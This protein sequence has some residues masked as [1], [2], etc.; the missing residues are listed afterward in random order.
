MSE[1]RSLQLTLVLAATIFIGQLHLF[2]QT[3]QTV[4]DFQLAPGQSSDGEGITADAIGNVF[5]GGN[6]YDAAGT[7]HGLVLKTDTTQATWYLS[8]DTNPNATQYQ[9]SMWNLGLDAG[10]NAYSIG[11][12]TPLSTGIPFWYVRKSSDSGQSW[13]TVDLYQYTAGKWIDATGFA[14]DAAGNIF[15]VG[16]GKDASGYNHWLVRK[17]TD[18]GQTWA[19]VDDVKGY[20][21]FH[22]G[23]VPGVGVFVVGGPYIIP[24]SW[25][26]RRSLDAGANWQTV[27]GPFAQGAARGVA[28]DSQGNIYVSGSMF[29][30]TQVLKVKGQITTN[31]YYAWITRRSG[32][33]GRT[34][35]TVDTYTYAP[36]QTAQAQGSGTTLTG[37][38]VVVGQARDAQ[39]Q[40]HWIVR[41]LGSSGWQTIDDFPGGIA[42]RV[43]SD[44]AGHLL[45]T[46]NASGRWIVRRL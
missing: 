27:D 40:E 20:S 12:L 46:G 21:G 11:Q 14:A 35:A 25:M 44:A 16:W 42:T 31:G 6:G 18:G 39:G 19:L 36:N 26:V 10:L 38:P 43:A 4:L 34:W 37:N 17:S 24:G 7:N 13:S 28:N 33:G 8:D 32:D 22:A 3:W 15:V 5:S 1:P 45:V 9:S 30:A 41:M 2:A 29:V 23:H